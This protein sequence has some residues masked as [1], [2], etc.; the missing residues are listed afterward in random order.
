MS[1]PE[2]IEAIWIV[3]WAVVCIAI[4]YFATRD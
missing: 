3:C 2:I 1:G 4:L